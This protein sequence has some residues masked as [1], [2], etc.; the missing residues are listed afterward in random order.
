MSLKC[1]SRKYV[2]PFQFRIWP[3]LPLEVV[4]PLDV[5]PVL[6]APDAAPEDVLPDPGFPA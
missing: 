1:V 6:A 3:L 2:S 5:L 4:L